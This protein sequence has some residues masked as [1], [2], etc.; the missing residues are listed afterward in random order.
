MKKVILFVCIAA[1]IGCK[2]EKS[3]D[4]LPAVKPEVAKSN[5]EVTLDM[6]VPEDDTFQVFY[7]E[8][9]SLDFGALNVRVRVPGSNEPQKIVFQLP[10]E[11]LPT[12]LRIDFGENKDQGEMTINNF[13]VKYYDQKLNA[14][15]AD[16]FKYFQPNGNLV[17]NGLK[18]TPANQTPAYDP[19][20]YPKGELNA[21]LKKILVK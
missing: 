1:F 2:K 13:E 5:V 6:V 8:D 17:V 14:K 20:F 4:D 19:M 11:A 15:G 10:D 12:I 16:F 9:N 18:I 21:A 3:L 7:T